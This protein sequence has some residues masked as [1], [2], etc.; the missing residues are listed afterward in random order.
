[1][2]DSAPKQVWIVPDGLYHP[3]DM[4]PLPAL[5]QEIREGDPFGLALT[6][7]LYD[8]HKGTFKPGVDLDR[9]RVHNSFEEC[10]AAML[11]ARVEDLETQRQWCHTIACEIEHIRTIPAVPFPE[12]VMEPPAPEPP[13]PPAVEQ[14]KAELKRPSRKAQ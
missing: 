3:G 12:V 13:A 1:M 4:A 10:R 7:A 5:V 6:V 11:A 9:S 8:R 14:P 2:S